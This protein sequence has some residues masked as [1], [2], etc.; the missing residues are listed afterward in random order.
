MKSCCGQLTGIVSCPQRDLCGKI[1][2]IVKQIRITFKIKVRK[3]QTIKM[4]IR[5]VVILFLLLGML[6]MMS[7]CGE[8]EAVHTTAGA[9]AD[10]MEESL[11]APENAAA[12][13]TIA[14]NAVI[15]E[16]D[17]ELP[18]EELIVEEPLKSQLTAELLEE[19]ELDAS[20][21]EN[22]RVTKGCTFDLPEG[23]EASEDVEGMYV[24]GRYPID[25]SSI[26]YVQM[27]Q[28]MALQLMTEESFKEHTQDTFREVYGEEVDL[29]VDSFEQIEMQGYPA[30]KILCHYQVE[31]VKV[32][33][34][35]YVINADKS[36]VITYSQTSDYDRMEEYEA[37]AET[38]RVEY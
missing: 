32:T 36:Y 13:E 8:E 14:G 20:V 30:F 35:A 34:L 6:G 37:S 23:F 12:E 38:I 31:D 28:D 24:T 4:N 17:S 18:A 21:M 33:Q 11:E 10:Q 25:A 27:D 1:D 3:V 15:S 16:E 2:K 7:G 29:I 9:E 22:T 19:N 5:K 26:Y